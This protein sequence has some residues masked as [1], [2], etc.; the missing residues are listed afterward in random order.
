ME[1]DEPQKITL[2]SALVANHATSP[3]LKRPMPV[4]RPPKSVPAF[5]R[6]HFITLILGLNTVATTST[7]GFRVCGDK[8]RPQSNIRASM[9]FC[10]ECT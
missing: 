9:G 8:L 4:P 7:Q 10:L 2:G 3:H 6:A 5:K 1:V